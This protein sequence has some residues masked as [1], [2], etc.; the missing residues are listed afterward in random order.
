MAT[1]T[2]TGVKDV[3]DP[4]HKLKMDVN[5]SLILLFCERAT[6]RKFTFGT[7]ATLNKTVSSRIALVVEFYGITLAQRP[8][9]MF[10]VRSYEIKNF[11]IIYALLH[12]VTGFVWRCISV[13][14]QSCVNVARYAFGA[15]KLESP[16]GRSTRSWCVF[17]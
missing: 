4:P 11:N 15:F 10:S 7:I 8:C 12:S 9:S 1:S 13:N 6:G 2:V 16:E 5:T 3:E 17:F 14:R